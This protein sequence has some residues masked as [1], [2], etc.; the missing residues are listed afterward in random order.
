MSFCEQ[1]LWNTIIW[2]FIKTINELLS[3]NSYDPRHKLQDLLIDPIWSLTLRI[4]SSPTFT[5]HPYH[6]VAKRILTTKHSVMFFDP[7][8]L[9]PPLPCWTPC[10][11]LT[12]SIFIPPPWLN[13]WIKYFHSGGSR[14]ACDPLP[15]GSMV[16]VTNFEDA[17]AVSKDAIVADI[18]LWTRLTAWL[19]RLNSVSSSSLPLQGEPPMLLFSLPSKTLSWL[20]SLH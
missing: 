4:H 14:G 7:Q 20:P 8:N 10:R 3:N 2:R 15:C 18:A 9:P 17:H 5:T 6:C 16:N 12:C 13:F 1:I 11:C 19:G